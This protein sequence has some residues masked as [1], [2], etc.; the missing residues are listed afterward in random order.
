MTPSALWI[1]LLYIVPAL[2]IVIY[3]LLTRKIGG[4]VIWEFSLDSYQKL[5]SYDPD[6]LFINSFIVIFM[7]FIVRF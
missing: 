3:S 1:G 4:G 5:F 2:L 6:S 7:L